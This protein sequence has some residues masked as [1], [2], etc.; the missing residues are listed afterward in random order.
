MADLP[1]RAARAELADVVNRAAYRG[2]RTKLMRRGKAVAAVVPV[3]DLEL[4]ERLEDEADAKEARRRLAAIKRGTETTE[5][6]EDV[7]GRLGV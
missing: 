7:L 1:I 5:P 3:E 2:E 6:L 4:L